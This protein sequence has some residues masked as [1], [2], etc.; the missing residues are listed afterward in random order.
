MAK[1]KKIF[2]PGWMDTVHNRVDFDGVDI[3]KNDFDPDQ[4][5]DAEYIVAHSA[6]ANYALLNWKNNKNAKLILIGPA[7]P[8][9]DFFVWIYRIIKFWFF[10]GT[11]FNKERKECFKYCFSNISKIKKIL[12]RDVTSI[13]FEIPKSDLTII[14]GKEDR[15]IFDDMIARQ[16]IAQGVN[17]IEIA[18]A[19]HHWNDRFREEVDRIIE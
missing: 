16:L 18:G 5:I 17:V 3:W 15:F 14:R 7:I 1:F 10:E 12:S 13:I 19:G 2:I 9:R 8:R 11:N 6:G 4:K